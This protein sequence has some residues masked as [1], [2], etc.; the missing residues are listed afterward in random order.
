MALTPDF[1]LH[2]SVLFPNTDETIP[3]ISDGNYVLN[4]LQTLDHDLFQNFRN[5]ASLSRSLKLT[6]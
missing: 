4:A 6:Q 3:D 1:D 2:L 5:P